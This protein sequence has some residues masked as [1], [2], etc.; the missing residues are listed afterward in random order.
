VGGRKVMERFSYEGSEH[1]QISALKWV[2]EGEIK[3]VIQIV[4]GM[5]EHIERYKEMAE[6]FNKKGIAVYGEDHRGHGH[7]AEIKKDLGHFYDKDGFPK[8]MNDVHGLTEVIKKEH[9]K[10]PIF[11]LG[12]SMGSFISR[13]IITIFPGDFKGVIISG[14]GNYGNIELKLNKTLLKLLLLIFGSKKVIPFFFTNGMND[15][16]KEFEP[17]RTDYDWLSTDPKV[18]DEFVEDPL[19]GS[20]DTLGFYRDLLDFLDNMQKKKNIARIPKTMPM[21]IFSGSM[22]PVGKNGKTS[23]IAYENYKKAGIKDITFKL[24]EGY[25]HEVHK[26]PVKFELFQEIVEWI[27]MRI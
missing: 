11:L 14:T 9:P 4:H 3:A 5:N 7:T 1:L 10:T 21:L 17:R 2:P 16:N 23:T 24:W 19:C 26:E 15:F 18:A 8:I 20:M 13:N 6:F 27:Q 25:R 12:H 22:D